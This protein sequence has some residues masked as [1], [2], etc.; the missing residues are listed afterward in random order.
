MNNSASVIAALI[1]HGLFDYP[2]T[3]EEIHKFQTKKTTL[4]QTR[5]ELEKLIKDRKILR[6]G[7][8]YFLGKNKKLATIR[9]NRQKISAKKLKRAKFYANILKSIPTIKLVAISG[10][11]AMENS[12]MSDDI[13]FL[14]IAAKNSL[15]TTRFLSNIMLLPF[16]RDSKSQ[17]QKDKAC[18]N[19][20]VDELGLKIKEQNL[21]KAHE[22]CQVKVLWDRNGTYQKFLNA[23]RWI[24]KFLPNWTPEYKSKLSKRGVTKWSPIPGNWSLLEILLKNFQLSYMKSKI[25]TEKIGE[26]QLFFHPG[27]TQSKVLKDYRNLTNKLFRST[28]TPHGSRKK[29]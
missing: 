28:I 16:K 20:F 14:I 26:H 23:N 13:D 4:V 21:Y 25:T 11:L 19:L 9:K 18:L 2:L 24:K 15:W 17:K 12:T 5:K 27:H 8:F 7:E 3:A 10:A 29:A 22:I 6:K 1:Y